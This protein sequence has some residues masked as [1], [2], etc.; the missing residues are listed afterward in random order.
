MLASL[1]RTIKLI[2]KDDFDVA[3]FKVVSDEDVNK[4]KEKHMNVWNFV[5]II[6]GCLLFEGWQQKSSG[7]WCFY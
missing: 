6:V 3:L 1:K 2:N 4:P 7:P 5:N